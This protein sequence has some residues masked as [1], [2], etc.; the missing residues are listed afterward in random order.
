MLSQGTYL[1]RMFGKQNKT[2]H[3]QIISFLKL[4]SYPWRLQ[5]NFQRKQLC[6]TQTPL[7]PFYSVWKHFTVSEPQPPHPHP[8]FSVHVSS[9]ACLCSFSLE[10]VSGIRR[11]LGCLGVSSTTGQLLLGTGRC[12]SQQPGSYV[13]QR[14]H[15]PSIESMSEPHANVNPYS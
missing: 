3:S 1:F 2:K 5:Q 6:S 10:A 14:G 4:P 15:F 13:S 12:G 11:E 9:M 7:V 8:C